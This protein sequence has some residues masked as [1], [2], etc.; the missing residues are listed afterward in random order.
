LSRLGLFCVLH[1]VSLR[2]SAAN[3]PKSDPNS[4]NS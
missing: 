3:G 2:Y 4:F 1:P